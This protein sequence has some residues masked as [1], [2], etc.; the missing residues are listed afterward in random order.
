MKREKVERLERMGMHFEVA[1]IK[2][3]KCPSCGEVVERERLRDQLSMTE[4][5]ISG[6]CQVDQDKVFG[7]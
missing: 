2:A 7:R 4:F 6:L 3:G 5:D 1:R